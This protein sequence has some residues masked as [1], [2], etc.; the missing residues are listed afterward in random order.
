MG[1]LLCIWNRMERYKN[2]IPPVLPSSI[3]CPTRCQR[4]SPVFLKWFLFS[5]DS[6]LTC[7]ILLHSCDLKISTKRS[8]SEETGV[9]VFLKCPPLGDIKAFCTTVALQR[10][11]QSTFLV[12][13]LQQ[14]QKLM[15]MF[16]QQ[17]HQ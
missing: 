5:G 10:I 3:K 6:L 11:Q 14:C 12:S 2:S 7:P 8:I 9:Q 4:P 17:S 16:A 13:F 1:K 15:Q